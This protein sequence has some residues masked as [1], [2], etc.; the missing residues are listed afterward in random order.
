MVAHT[1]FKV[2]IVSPIS[3]AHNHINAIIG[4]KKPGQFSHVTR[5]LSKVGRL[6]VTQHVPNQGTV[7]V[8]V[9]TKRIC[10]S[11]LTPILPPFDPLAH[12]GTG[13]ATATHITDF[14]GVARETHSGNN[15]HRDEHRFARYIGPQRVLPGLTDKR[16]TPLGHSAQVDQDR[17]R[18]LRQK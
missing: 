14:L 16:D 15:G 6:R 3:A 8:L 7:G 1:K 12:S 18:H 5:P 4:T 9:M 2:D 10:C 13:H 17:R 11:A